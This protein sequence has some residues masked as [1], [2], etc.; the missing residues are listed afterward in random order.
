M[1]AVRW[2]LSRRQQPKRQ[3]FMFE[4]GLNNGTPSFNA[5]D[6]EYVDGYGWD[7]DKFPALYSAKQRATYGASG[8]GITRL[9]TNFSN[10]HMVRAVGTKLQ[11]DNA[12]TWTDIAGTFTDTDWD[13]TNFDVSGLALILTNGTDNVKYWNGTALADLN[14]ANA[15]K[16]KYIAAD[17][18]RVYIAV[19]DTVHY[20]AFQNATDW[21]TAENSGQVQIWTP[22]GGDVTG[23]KGFEGK[24]W[25]FKKDSLG[26]IFH[27]GDSRVTHRLVETSNDVGCIAYKTIVEV[28]QYLFWLGPNDVYYGAGGG[29]RAI[30]QPIRVYLDSINQTHVSKCNGFT[31]GLRYYLN[32]VTGSNTEPNIRLVYD[33]RYETWNISNLTE[34]Y[35]FGTLFNNVLYA[36]D[37]GGQT[38]KV[39]GTT[40]GSY[41]V[42]TKDFDEGE[43]EAEKEYYELHL[44]VTAPSGT[45]LTVEASVNQGGTYTTLTSSL[46]VSSAAQNVNVI[47]PLDTVPLGN[48][49]RFRISGSGEFTLHSCQRYFRTQPVQH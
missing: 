33:P 18:R 47:V 39:K 40:F 15:P 32:L 16:G 46:A 31:D 3:R 41:Q 23:L 26:I 4:G 7:T 22:N 2:S 38:Y 24:I 43:P 9:L 11:Y 44:Q 35:R 21:T 1:V 30:G 29:Y 5:K 25:V 48:W 45:T 13:A 20:C 17:N 12:G 6:N 49:I 10:T 34:E 28:G 36:G 42:V 8:G 37:D 14:A 19:G 27:T